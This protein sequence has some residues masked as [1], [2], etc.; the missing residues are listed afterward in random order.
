MKNRTLGET[1]LG[2]DDSI[3]VE[4]DNRLTPERLRYE[5]GRLVVAIFGAFAYSA[6][7]NLFVVPLGLYTGGLMGICQLIRSIL[8]NAFGLNFGSFDIAGLIYYA[9]NIPLFLLARKKM[10]RIYFIKTLICVTSTTIFLMLIPIP[11]T[12]IIDDV[13]AACV[14]AGIICG[15]GIGLVLRMGATDGGMDIVGILLIRWRRDFSVGKVNLFVNCLL[16]GV[17]FFLFNVQTVIYS[18]I[19]AAFSATAIDRVH[20]QNINVEVHIITRVDC[21]ALERRVFQELG[22]GITKWTSVG[23]YTGN[24]SEILYVIV[25][26]YELNHLRRIVSAYDPDAFIVT[27]EGV[28]VDGHFNKHLN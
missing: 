14:I 16:Y 12:V 27:T 20:A 9:M 28:G 7:I 17:C 21:D 4:E 1:L 5:A 13:L 15:A 10:G 24:E 22:R 19:Y 6:G 18:L 23:A 25:S 26:K 11:Q 8:V 2:T 3:N